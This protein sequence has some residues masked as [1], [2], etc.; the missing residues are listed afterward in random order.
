MYKCLKCNKTF[1][2]MGYLEQHMLKNDLP[3]DLV[4]CQCGIKQQSKKAFK[5][6]FPK[7]CQGKF[8]VVNDDVLADNTNFSLEFKNPDLT[9]IKGFGIFPH[10]V[11]QFEIFEKY[12]PNIHEII[13]KYLRKSLH[14]NQQTIKQLTNYKSIIVSIVSFI[15]SNPLLPQF[16]NIIDINPIDEYYRLFDGTTFVQ[17]IM[18]KYMRNKR[19]LQLLLKILTTL[20]QT[21]D[22]HPEVRR[23]I[24]EC[25][26]RDIVCAYRDK[27]Y[28]DAMQLIWQQNNK[29]IKDINRSITIPNYASNETLNLSKQ[30]NEYMNEDAHLHNKLMLID[31]EICLKI[32]SEYERSPPFRNI[33]SYLN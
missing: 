26:M 31:R 3:C 30:L 27:T 12:L 21:N 24:N 7:N 17:D 15:Y 19:I 23:F 22:S 29:N 10:E 16:V 18:P 2:K 20:S 13:L 4:C 32:R 1:T 25:F 8:K 5:H 28:N 9:Y 6:H 33:I 14:F 11:E